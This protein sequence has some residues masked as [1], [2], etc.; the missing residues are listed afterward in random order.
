MQCQGAASQ[1]ADH[2]SSSVNARICLECSQG[3]IVLFF[4]LFFFVN[5]Y[6]QF[7]SDE[8]D[9]RVCSFHLEGKVSSKASSSQKKNK[10]QRVE[11]YSITPSPTSGSSSIKPVNIDNKKEVIIDVIPLRLALPISP[12]LGQAPSLTICQ[13]RSPLLVPFP[14]MKIALS[15]SNPQVKASPSLFRIKEGFITLSKTI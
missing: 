8:V 7:C 1:R 2:I 4:F 15:S 9:L 3:M 5:F 13:G 11:A 14:Y 10:K 12:N 6:T